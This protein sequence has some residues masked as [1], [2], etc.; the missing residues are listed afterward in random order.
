MVASVLIPG[1]AY[2]VCWSAALTASGRPRAARLGATSLAL[3]RDASGSPRA[4]VD[5]CPHRGYPLS[6]GRVARGELH[7]GYHGW[8]F[9]PD[10]AC[11][12][13][14][15]RVD[16]GAGSPACA[17]THAAADAHGVTWVSAHPGDSAAHIPD[18]QVEAAP[19]AFTLR[20]SQALDGALVDVA[21]N[22]L[23]VV[24]T[25]FLHRGIF[26]KPG[27]G[28]EIEARATRTSSRMEVDYVGEPVPTGLLGRILAPRGGVV[29]HVDRF[30]M[31]CVAQVEYALGDRL[32][33]RATSFLVP[34]T[35][36][37]TRALHVVSIAPRAL[38]VTVLP[39]FAPLAWHV[40]RQDA[41]A[42]RFQSM[43][44]A[45]Q[46]DMRLT[47]TELDIIGPHVRQM[48]ERAGREAAPLPDAAWSVKL[49]V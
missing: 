49:S 16:S 27:R 23:D 13:V 20:W 46:P 1:H 3:F 29:T 25:A 44:L 42:L 19:D 7:C 39:A 5:A 2:P 22:I 47:S 35:P 48:L 12:A 4:F 14:P 32:R 18:I 10:G 8:R 26:R 30:V 45:R 41:R 17:V 15:G 40:L 33:L 43:S 9:S 36:S 37:R 31:P 11:V 28:I 6:E 34:E 24:H 38:A 21:E